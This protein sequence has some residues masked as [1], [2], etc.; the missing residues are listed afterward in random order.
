MKIIT[1]V[2]SL[3]FLNS[4]VLDEIL[5][6][7]ESGSKSYAVVK[8]AN[9]LNKVANGLETL[10][11]TRKIKAKTSDKFVKGIGVLISKQPLKSQERLISQSIEA[12]VSIENI[13]AW[14]STATI[15]S[16]LL[17]LLGLIIILK[18]L[19]D[20]VSPKVKKIIT[21]HE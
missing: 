20:R 15:T 18:Y 6:A 7:G 21:T 3:I 19:F 5:K 4:C 17:G 8:T 11:D 9:S 1:I 14:R 13:R 12:K 16:F 2:F 10:A